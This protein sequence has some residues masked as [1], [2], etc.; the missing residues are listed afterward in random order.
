MTTDA[1]KPRAG[2]PGAAGQFSTAYWKEARRSPPRPLIYGIALLLLFAGLFVG[3]GEAGRYAD[4]FLLTAFLCCNLGFLLVVPVL[5]AKEA[6]LRGRLEQL[7]QRLLAV[8]S[9][10][11][12]AIARAAHVGALIEVLKGPS[13]ILLAAFP[14][15]LLGFLA[16]SHLNGRYNSVDPFLLVGAL[17]AQTLTSLLLGASL[18]AAPP[19]FKYPK[20]KF[21]LGL[22]VGAVIMLRLV[23]VIFMSEPVRPQLLSGLLFSNEY[24]LPSPAWAVLST[25]LLDT[26]LCLLLALLCVLAGA[27]RYRMALKSPLPEGRT[28]RQMLDEGGEGLGLEVSFWSLLR[29]KFWRDPLYKAER[30]SLWSRRNLLLCWA[31]AALL[32]VLYAMIALEADNRAEGGPG[33]LNSQE[34]ICLFWLVILVPLLFAPLIT[35]IGISRDKRTRSLESLL[36]TPAA[37]MRLAAAKLLGRLKPLAIATAAACLACAAISYWLEVRFSRPHGYG[38]WFIRMLMAGYRFWAVVAIFV[39]PVAVLAMGCVGLFF[40]TRVR[41]TILALV[42]TVLASTAYVLLCVVAASA[43][44]ATLLNDNHLQSEWLNSV[45]GVAAGL[46]FSGLLLRV[47][48]SETAR[49]FALKSD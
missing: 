28:D 14:S 43:L 25:L 47:F 22:V 4:D 16:S 9:G 33:F 15:Y 27:N 37:P 36:L 8:P 24:I 32:C 42:L 3:L 44:Y 12:P 21:L 26:P 34:P 10:R 2:A 6:G 11:E 30:R 45:A 20:G 7:R 41:S 23:A 17:W 49:R 5:A 19:W 38:L 29:W 40:G 1:S 39:A 46:L 18:G 31:G 13:V 35:V 48:L